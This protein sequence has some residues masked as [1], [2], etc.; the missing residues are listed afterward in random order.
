[1]GKEDEVNTGE[2]NEDTENKSGSSSDQST[3]DQ[4]QSDQQTGDQQSKSDDKSPDTEWEKRFKGLQ[5]K[6]FRPLVR[7]DATATA[8]TPVHGAMIGHLDQIRGDLA[9][10]I[11]RLLDDP[12]AARNLARVMKR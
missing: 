10:Q 5:P 4:S 9:E 12:T 7:T 3:G 2:G 1:M 6:R 8:A 11:A